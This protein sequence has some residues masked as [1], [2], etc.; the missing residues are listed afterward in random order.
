MLS[1]LE[2]YFTVEEIIASQAWSAI[3]PV[4]SAI[5]YMDY[6]NKQESVDIDNSDGAFGS[7]PAIG[8]ITNAASVDIYGVELEL[9][10]QPWEGGFVSVDLGYLKSESAVI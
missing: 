7:D 10:A 8:I 4:A 5:F 2:L 9:R 3:G 6:S 1:L